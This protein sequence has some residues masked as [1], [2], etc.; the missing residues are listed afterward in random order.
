MQRNVILLINNISNKV[1]ILFTYYFFCLLVQIRRYDNNIVIKQSRGHRD[2]ATQRT[3]IRNNYN[4]ALQHLRS[5]LVESDGSLYQLI[6]NCPCVFF[7]IFINVLFLFYLIGLSN[8]CFVIIF[9]RHDVS[10]SVLSLDMLLFP[11]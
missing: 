8:R 10:I 5:R 2:K 1:I 7:C 4:I 3:Y 9:D 6:M 11:F